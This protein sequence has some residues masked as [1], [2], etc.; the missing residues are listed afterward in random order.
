MEYGAPAHTHSL[1]LYIC[2]K[3]RLV[4]V[5]VNLVTALWTGEYYII[6]CMQCDCRRD[7]DWY[8][9]RS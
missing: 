4:K 3:Y 2:L 6:L 1:T 7:L 9:H 5:V 8:T